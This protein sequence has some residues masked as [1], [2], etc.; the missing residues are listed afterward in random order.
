MQE[1]KQDNKENGV[2]RGKDKTK[3]VKS[4]ASSLNMYYKELI[5]AQMSGS[6]I[7][8]NLKGTS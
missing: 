5:S 7:G 8:R 3:H 6:I 1:T 2:R 4:Q